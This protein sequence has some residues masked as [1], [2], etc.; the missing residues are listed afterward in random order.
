MSFVR[1]WF[2]EEMWRLGITWAETDHGILCWNCGK[3]FDAGND[4]DLTCPHCEYRH[5][6]GVIPSSVNPAIV[7]VE[8]KA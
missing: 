2:Q 5:Q 4:G 6:S 1:N 8:E 3:H 7:L